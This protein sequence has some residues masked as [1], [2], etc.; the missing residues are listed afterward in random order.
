[1]FK[2]YKYNVISKTYN[3]SFFRFLLLSTSHVG[4]SEGTFC[5]VGVHMVSKTNTVVFVIEL[6]QKCPA[7]TVVLAVLS[8]LTRGF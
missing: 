2:D 4:M 7:D 3:T 5:R 6:K 8:M 1:M